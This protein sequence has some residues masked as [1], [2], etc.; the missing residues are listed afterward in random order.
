MDKPKF[1]YMIDGKIVKRDRPMRHLIRAIGSIVI[2][3][4]P[5]DELTQKPDHSHQHGENE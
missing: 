5:D 4:I 1:W 3:P 2:I